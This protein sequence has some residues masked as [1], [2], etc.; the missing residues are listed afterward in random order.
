MNPEKQRIVIAESC[1]WFNP[2]HLKTQV[3]VEGWWSQH[4]NVWWL[5]PD[6]ETLAMI[7]DVP[8]YLTDR[9]AIAEAKNLKWG[10]V[11]FRAR[12]ATILH[13]LCGFEPLGTLNATPSQEAEAYLKALNLWVGE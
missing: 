7:S 4:R 2:N 3:K 5:K 6:G 9:N 12:F 10:D 8:N 13:G 1:G 11:K